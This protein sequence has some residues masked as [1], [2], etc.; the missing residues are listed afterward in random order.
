MNVIGKI[1]LFID[2]KQLA[3]RNESSSL[4]PAGCPVA[5][6]GDRCVEDP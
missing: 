2:H 4:D 6:K 1:P 3:A 5:F